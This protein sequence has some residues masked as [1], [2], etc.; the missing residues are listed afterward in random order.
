M[1]GW[2]HTV[3]DEVMDG[4][5][6]NTGSGDY[7]GCIKPTFVRKGIQRKEKRKL[8]GELYKSYLVARRI[9]ERNHK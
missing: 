6:M 7:Y 4:N 8:F 3:E 5:A 9:K 1:G 2:T